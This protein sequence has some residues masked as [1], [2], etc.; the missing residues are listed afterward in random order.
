MYLS[1]AGAASDHDRVLRARA[2]PLCSRSNFEE[3]RGGSN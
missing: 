3:I 2:M 1:A